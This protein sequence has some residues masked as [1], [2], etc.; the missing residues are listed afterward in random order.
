MKWERK[1]F[2]PSGARRLWL[3]DV[4]GEVWHYETS[5]G[6]PAG[7]AFQGKRQRPTWQHIFRNFS[8]R[9]QYTT[10]FFR[11]LKASAE[12]KAR[13]KAEEVEALAKVKVDPGAVFYCSW[14]YDQT[15]IDFFQVVK[16]KGRYAWLRPLAEKT[17]EQTGFMSER[18]TAVVGEFRGEE[19]RRLIQVSGDRPCFRWDKGRYI[20]EWDGRPLHQSHY[21]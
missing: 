21:A 10:E 13:E 19:I 16:V 11:N 5:Q 1:H 3:P 2:I 6:K 8:Q 12:R 20:Y 15:N 18:V 7:A 4:P 9:Q 17:T 14:G